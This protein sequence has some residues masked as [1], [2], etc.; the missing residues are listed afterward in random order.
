MLRLIALILGSTIAGCALAASPG[1][2]IYETHC[3]ACHGSDGKGA[4]PGVPDFTQKN[5]VL[6]LPAAVLLKRIEHGYQA[7]GA[8]MAMPARGGDAS[9]T[10]QQIKLVLGYVRSRFRG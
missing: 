1:Q 10:D 2:T 5:G 6:S 7:P 8:P 3:S 9:L 4:F